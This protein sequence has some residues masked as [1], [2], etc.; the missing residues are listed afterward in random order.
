MVSEP[1]PKPFPFALHIQIDD[2]RWYKIPKLKSR[3]EQAAAETLAQL[4]KNLQR[5]C[6]LTLLLGTDKM[7]RTLNRDFRGL[8][9]PTNVL[10]FPQ[11]G[12]EKELKSASRTEPLYVGDIAI[13]YQYMVDESKKYNKILINHLTHL[14]IH[15]IL[16]LFGYDHLGDIDAQRMERLEKKIMRRLGLPDP[17]IAPASCP[18]Q[19]RAKR[20]NRT[21]K[22]T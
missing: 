14:M 8:D 18:E 21:K 7:I 20:I 2:K 10:S 13:A 6:S 1:M 19:N 4:P 11:F 22:H 16:H 9:K 15:G 17:Y 5:P 3:M 12:E